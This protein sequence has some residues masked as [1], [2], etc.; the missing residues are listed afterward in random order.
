[1]VLL[2]HGLN[3]RC[4]S[5]NAIAR[6]KADGSAG[7]WI[8]RAA[9]EGALEW[10]LVSTC[11]RSELVSVHDAPFADALTLDTPFRASGSEALLHLCAVAAGLESALFGEAAV[12]G[13]VR[14]AF[15]DAC[16]AG[17]SGPALGRVF[18][19]AFRSAR[20]VRTRMGLGDQGPSWSAL[21]AAKLGAERGALADLRV[22]VLGCGP[23]GESIV[24][25][26]RA[27][28]ANVC[29][30]GSDAR[31]SQLLA[32]E[33]GSAALGFE[34]WIGSL[35]LFDVVVAASGR[36]LLLDR[37]AIVA[38]LA[39]RARANPLEIWDLAV[40]PNVGPS[41]AGWSG[42]RLRGASDLLVP[43]AIAGR[44]AE[45]TEALALLRADVDA[46]FARWGTGF[47]RHG[48]G[49]ESPSRPAPARRG[50]GVGPAPRGCVSL[51][52]A[53][54]GDPGLL[55]RA[56]LDRLAAAD[57]VLHDALLPP[58]L[59]AMVPPAAGLVPVGKRAGHP[60]TTQASIEA[61][62]IEEARAGRRVVRLKGGDP[63]LFGRG[64]EEIEALDGAG[65]E[66]EVVPGIT[67]ALAAA[68]SY[69]I[70]LTH[71][72][73]SHGA[74]MLTG[75]RAG[76]CAEPGEE[77]QVVYM[78]ARRLHETAAEFLASGY[79]PATPVA[80]VE[81]ASWPDASCRRTTL[82]E[83]V[84]GAE[85]ARARTPALLV[86]GPT[87]GRARSR[88]EAARGPRIA[89]AG[90]LQ[91]LPSIGATLR[92]S[93]ARTLE[94][95]LARV[96]AHADRGALAHAAGALHGFEAIAFHD[97]HAVAPLF[98]LLRAE[99]RDVR[100]LFGLRL[101]AGDERTK[102]ALRARGLVPDDSAP[103]PGERTLV[104]A[105]PL[106][107]EAD[108]VVRVFDLAPMTPDLDGIY[109]ELADD[110]PA[111]WLVTS[112]AVL[113]RLFALFADEA[114]GPWFALDDMTL[115]AF[116]RAGRTAA[117]WVGALP[118]GGPVYSQAEE[119]R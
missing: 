70:P 47:A 71:R 113:A 96:V 118:S 40:P 68:A 98:D 14:R 56:A 109:G 16:D 73:L 51:V 112:Q 119:A 90:I 20:R 97:V 78:S 3:L 76:S 65:I 60:G 91:D 54:P 87:A 111:G 114:R 35:R 101:I 62:M 92:A 11:E 57:L 34:D 94:I 39:R 74:R 105:G 10:I 103:L 44:D 55:T 64:G 80:L 17:S 21:L 86:V 23:L 100:A 85:G 30:S 15:T 83:L 27:A 79:S 99:E 46:F 66:W 58:G 115:R 24:R 6:A 49:P 102:E 12:L 26:L 8:A 4:A 29:L 1:M 36:G 116:R 32:G 117:P 48:T 108:G 52:G 37:A 31:R 53:G 2:A 42:V 28:G 43:G 104:L 38:P 110:P 50:E 81:R 45:R 77:T 61:R 41:V 88:N 25:A 59:L 89:V 72:A 84:A 33:T 93:G 18:H 69:G 9:R 75:T 82:G 19:Q 63:L 13:Q 67:A 22:G 106:A 95:P 5:P 7:R 107:R